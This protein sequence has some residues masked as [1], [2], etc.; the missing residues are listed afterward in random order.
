MMTKTPLTTMTASATRRTA[1]AGAAA[2]VALPR[3]ARAQGGPG[4]SGPIPLGSLLPMSGSGGPYGPGIRTAQQLAVDEINRAG[5]VLGRPLVLVGED[6]QTNPEAG[7]RAARKMIDVD[8]VTCMLGTW[9]SS[10]ASAVAPLCWESKVMMICVGAADSITQLPHGGYIV[11]TQPSTTLQSEQFAKFAILEKARHLYILMPQTP[12][13]QATF[14]LVTAGCAPKGIKVSTAIY[15]AKKTG[16]RS[17]VDALMGSGADMLI[18]GGYLAD[19]VVLAKDVYRADFK[20]KAVGYA[21][22]MGPQFVAAAGK[23]VADGMFSLEPTPDAASSAYAHLTKAL[24]KG[25]PDIYTCHGY[26]EVNLA[27]LAMA[28]GGAASGTAIKDNIR[29]IGDPAGVKVDNGP[30]GLKA[31]KEGK[32][33]NYLGASGVCKF[34][35]NGDVASAQFKVNVVRNGTIETYRTL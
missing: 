13:T 34:A 2:L 14:D 9:A 7:V 19:T 16:F 6:D 23:Q 17:E 12:F 20:G 21:Y 24:G 8:K 25:S 3:L 29:R 33:I 22:A 26:D 35:P 10:V 5:G 18:M 15:D 11:R 1:L 4:P 30:D 28:A 27:A 32:P 31:L